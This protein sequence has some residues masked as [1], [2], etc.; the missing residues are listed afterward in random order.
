MCLNPSSAFVWKKC[1]GMRSA[2]EIARELTTFHNAE[3]TEEFV[4]LAISEL[5]R[6][7]LLDDNDFADN[8]GISRRQLIKKVGMA[9]MIALPVVV[10]FVAPTATHA[11]SCTANNASCTASAQCCSNCCKN[12]SPSINQCKP[13]SGACLP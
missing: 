4:D 2:G 7:D 10:S 8:P 6:F 12:V 11:Q 13:G 5:A 3:V 9:S 1:D